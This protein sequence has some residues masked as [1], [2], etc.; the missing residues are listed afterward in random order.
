MIE[1]SQSGISGF[2]SIQAAVD[3]AAAAGGTPSLVLIRD[4][5]Y[6]E[7]VRIDRGI[8]RV[9]GESSKR[10]ILRHPLQITGGEVELENIQNGGVMIGQNNVRKVPSMFFCGSREAM[11]NEPHPLT[12]SLYDE[13]L[14]GC[15]VKGAVVMGVLGRIELFLRPGDTLAVLLGQAEGE[16]GPYFCTG[17]GREFP[18]YLEIA[19]NTALENS[20]E[21]RLI[22]HCGL[23]KAHRAAAMAYAMERG[24]PF[25]QKAW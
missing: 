20:A 22:V 11:P 3:A 4:G 12:I 1:V 16:P 8:L 2:R 6:E 13:T 23:P 25:F 15:T 5:V 24:I 7:S 19:R 9:V 18:L 10:V 17:S 14:P 21:F